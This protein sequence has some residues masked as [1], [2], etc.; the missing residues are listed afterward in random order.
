MVLKNFPTL[1]LKNNCMPAS[2]GT[3][4]V[5]PTAPADTRANPKRAN[6]PTA[7]KVYSKKSLVCTNKLFYICIRNGKMQLKI[8]WMSLLFG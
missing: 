5:C 4:G 1:N 2:I 3:F 6:F 7:Q 8:L